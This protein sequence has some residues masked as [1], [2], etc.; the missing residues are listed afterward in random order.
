MAENIIREGIPG[1]FWSSPASMYMSITAKAPINNNGCIE[2]TNTINPI[3]NISIIPVT[4][5][6][7]IFHPPSEYFPIPM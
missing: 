7:A 1:S 3:R 5:P 6:S 4:F 2:G